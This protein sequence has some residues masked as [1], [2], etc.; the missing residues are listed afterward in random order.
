MRSFSTSAKPVRESAILAARGNPVKTLTNESTLLK[1]PMRAHSEKS[2]EFCALVEQSCR[3]SAGGYL[4]LFARKPR[5]GWVTWG[6]EVERQR[7]NEGTGPN[8]NRERQAV[9]RFFTETPIEGAATFWKGLRSFTLLRFSCQ[10]LVDASCTRMRLT[11]VACGYL[12]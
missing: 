7:R 4:E 3:A 6:D 1:A 8:P 10:R 5:P 12:E 11:I 2:D 9:D